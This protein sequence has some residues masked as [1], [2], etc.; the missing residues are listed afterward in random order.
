MPPIKRA[1]RAYKK[2]GAHKDT[3]KFIIICEGQREGKYFEYF[4]EKYKRLVVQVLQPDNE[5][6]GHSAPIKLQ[7]RASE[8]ISSEDWDDRLDDEIWF[9]VD[10]DRWGFQLN[11]LSNICQ[12]ARNWFLANSNP[13]FEVWLIYHRKCALVNEKDPQKV[14]QLLHET[15]AGGYKLETWIPKIDKAIE[16]SRRLDMH[17]DK[18][19]SG[20]G[21]TK[22]YLLAEKILE[23]I[24]K[25]NG[26]ISL[27]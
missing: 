4:K 23:L 8:Y 20:P 15:V 24:P 26:M 3:R 14:K 12:S 6:H 2:E 22:V 27:D 10:Y 25:E 5:H 18:D 7:E 13:C 19:I 17:P 9:I 21:I 16:C 11:E 1:N